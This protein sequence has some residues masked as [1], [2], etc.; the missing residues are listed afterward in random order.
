MSQF[1]IRAFFDKCKSKDKDLRIM[2]LYDL[3]TELEKESFKFDENTQRSVAD[4]VLKL[5]DDKS[6]EVQ[7]MAVK[8]LEPLVKKLSQDQ[9]ENCINM[10]GNY[11]N[12]E[13]EE[14]RD[15]ASISLKIIV[16][17]IPAEMARVPIKKC[18]GVLVK[19][20]K[21][22]EPEVVVE[23]LDILYELLSRF[24]GILTDSH[25]VLQKILLDGL[26]SDNSRI[27]KR[28][29]SA[30]SALSVHTNETLF[31]DVLEKV[32][33]GLG[34]KDEELRTYIFAVST[35]SKQAGHR[36]GKA[37]STIF[38]LL[39]NAA[40]KVGENE[41]E[42]RENIIQSFENFLI[43]CPFETVQFID[44]IVIL[45]KEYLEYDPN[46]SYDSSG[47]D[48][49]DE[50]EEKEEEEN[51]EGGEE[52]GEDDEAYSDDDDISWKVRKAAAKCLKTLVASRPDK[53]SQI[54]TELSSTEDYTLI[55]RFKEREESVKLAVFEIFNELLKQTRKGPDGHSKPEL[56]FVKA[57]LTTIMSR[58]KK[59]LKEKSAKVRQGVFRVLNNLVE[60]LDGGLDEYIPVLVNA[61]CLS[62]QDAN[63]KSS[64]KLEVL[65]LLE[66]LLS[67]HDP[68][69]FT[70]DI[71]KITKAVF[72]C[73]DDR[74]YKVISKSLLV[75]KP[76]IPVVE[77]LKGTN[78]NEFD[79]NVQNI[80][81]SIHGRLTLQDIDQE[82]KESAIESMAYLIS[83]VGSSLKSTL[84]KAL[85][86][87]V[88]KL[89][90]EVTRLTS[91][92]A[93]GV[94]ASSSK[95]VDLKVVLDEV[96][97]LLS[98]YLK[99]SNRTIRQSSL[100]S[101]AQLVE[102]YGDTLNLNQF[103]NIITNVS[104][105]LSRTKDSDLYLTHLALK[106]TVLLIKANAKNSKSVE[107]DI[108]PIGLNLLQSSS[109]QG[110]A[111]D[112]LSNLLT[113]LIESIG[114]SNLFKSL[115]SVLS[116][117]KNATQQIYINVGRCIASILIK[118]NKNDSKSTID[119]FTKDLN[120]KE[121]GSKLLSLFALGEIGR[122]VDLSSYTSIKKDIE[123]CFESGSE[124][125]KNAAS[126]SLGNI[127][128]GNLKTYLPFI[129]ENSRKDSSKKYLLIH[130]LKEIIT[131]AESESIK[132]YL[133]D[134]IPLL[135][136]NCNNEKEGIR[137]VVS[138]C[139]GKLALSDYDNVM[140]KLK[141][142]LEK[143]YEKST[144]ISSVK[145]C[146][147]QK[148]QDFDKSLKT[149]LLSFLSL[150]KDKNGSPDLKK[151]CIVLLTS[152]LH[153]KP[154]LVLES[155][156]ELLPY[157]YEQSVL[158]KSLLKV[159]P[160]GPFK[161][162]IDNGLD[163]R[164]SAFVCMDTLLDTC[165]S[166]IDTV[167]FVQQFPH[168]LDDRDND[169]RMLVGTMVVKAAQLAPD[170]I[171]TVVDDICKPL[172][173][174]LMK[175]LKDNSVQTEKETHAELIKS[176]L[177]AVSAL[178]KVKGTSDSIKFTDL[179]GYIESNEN[180]AFIYT[181]FQKKK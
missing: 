41:D 128:V 141:G 98:D 144:I 67:F 171:L 52:G 173:K 121:E 45:A 164:K 21:S 138:E 49:E 66:N 56:K 78:D 89:K 105:L 22:K 33:K 76:L 54:Y 31:K 113:S 20:L 142:G 165:F 84:D 140:K 181:S 5:L 159:V 100:V 104:S 26:S 146:I 50:K 40:D 16:S 55:S 123:S 143:D 86:L 15:I 163:L 17:R 137:N 57:T 93:F 147:T 48:E 8:C 65:Q 72:V 110:S 174:T 64:I 180:L 24:G 47:D 69:L 34:T 94:I 150:I 135:F 61:I 46:Y 115:V 53:L 80:Y 42:V 127:S 4:E 176:S 23:S 9:I 95:K 19:A 179:V 27:R 90:N 120:S 83:S 119:K 18:V 158:N 102:N 12:G 166:T 75:L 169:V 36:L 178:T 59:Q 38:P 111:L 156:G 43:R 13:E 3:N 149:D 2:A 37:L 58:L 132:G 25:E 129:I 136:E 97:N 154:S 92:R 139:L 70:K 122:K 11:I 145:Y 85:P 10:L 109:L 91:I 77:T 87:L 134:I 108:L 82:V 63:N 1:T 117:V 131:Q 39:L 161:H 60:T 177:K 14:K 133:D 81:K 130:S 35:I 148:K 175:K 116:L 107:T 6:S 62:L 112:E 170:S 152:A 162:T 125:I 124:E 29:I 74:Y 96:V 71:N 73:V 28:S 103:K 44:L 88:D 126:Y 168:G 51:E 32:V 167:K 157:I 68:K 153:S 106:L 114:F 160:L 155:L 151:S 118:A 79:A 7:G 30:I 172:K 99:K 101:L